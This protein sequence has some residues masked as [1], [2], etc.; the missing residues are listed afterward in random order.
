MN[1]L[2]AAAVV[3]CT[4]LCEDVVRL[5]EDPAGV[6]IGGDQQLQR[7]N[8]NVGAQSPEV[9]LLQVVDALQLLHLNTREQTG[10]PQHATTYTPCSGLTVSSS[11]EVNWSDSVQLKTESR[12][13]RRYSRMSV[14]KFIH[15]FRHYSPYLITESSFNV[16]HRY[17]G[18]R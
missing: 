7:S 15:S 11:D 14:W 8:V 1:P 5:A 3:V 12:S 4:Y 13:F 6:G 2:P 18:T 17:G 16:K 10:V 9:R